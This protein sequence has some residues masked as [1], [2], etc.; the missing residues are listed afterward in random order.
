MYIE[1]VFSYFEIVRETAYVFSQT[2]KQ[3]LLCNPEHSYVF[4]S[5]LKATGL[6]CQFIQRLYLVGL[7]KGKVYI[8]SEVT[9]G[10]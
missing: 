3:G 4:L 1:D 10:L 7:F 2:I 8:C 6:H 9:L 5:P